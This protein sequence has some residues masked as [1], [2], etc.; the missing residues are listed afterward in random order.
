MKK[1]IILTLIFSIN[2]SCNMSQ[3]KNTIYASIETNKGI[4]KM[5]LFFEKTPITVANFISL[6]DGSNKNVIDEY[7]NKKYYNGLTFH[8]VIS[9]F[10]I[11]GGDPTGTGSGSPGYKFKDENIIYAIIMSTIKHS[12]GK[13]NVIPNIDFNNDIN[14]STHYE[15]RVSPPKVEV[16]YNFSPFETTEIIKDSISNEASIKNESISIFDDIDLKLINEYPV[17]DF[18]NK[19]LITKSKTDL[20]VIDIKRAYYRIYYEQLLDEISNKKN[21]SQRL[22]YPIEISFSPNDILIIK[23][24]KNILNHLGFVFSVQK[25]N[26][27]VKSIH[28]IFDFKEVESVFMYIVEKN[29]SGFEE[30][31]PSIND[32]ITKLLAKAKSK[33]ILRLKNK[34]EQDLLLN[35]IFN[36][37]ESNL[38]P[39]NKKIIFKFSI[40]NINSKFN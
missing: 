24:V 40:D 38:C 3:E 36:C 29:S 35:R 11:Q 31:Y 28:P 9:D 12:L 21:L 5:E 19:F 8:R 17:F 20:L 18:S 26:I 10:M 33:K 23:S 34:K 6:S 2:L 15:M 39:Q 7:K 16:D 4:I 27:N 30:L 32:H 1:I 13:F 22:L 25:N 14:L 37:K